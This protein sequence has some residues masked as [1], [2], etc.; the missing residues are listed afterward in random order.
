M[1]KLPDGWSWTTGNR[2]L[3]WTGSD[4]PAHGFTTRTGGL[5]T[6]PFA[7]LNISVRHGDDPAHVDRNLRLIRQD[8]GLDRPWL[9]TDQ[10]HGAEAFVVTR[11]SGI[12]AGTRADALLTNLPDTAIAV[13]VADC[14]P[15]LAWAPDPVDGR[16][17]GVVVAIHAGWRGTAGGVVPGTLARAAQDLG[18]P[19]AKLTFLIGASARSCCYEVG[20]EVVSAL[21]TAL[22]LAGGLSPQDE[23][24]SPPWVDRSRGKARV[25]PAVVAR[26]QLRA[27]GVPVARIHDVGLC[28]LCQ[29]DVWFSYRRDGVRSGRALGIISNGT[30][31]RT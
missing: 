7:S 12:P 3:T 28:T 27:A 16:P 23:Q 13:G 6:G 29:P 14:T 26:A 5:S 2:L 20:D 30:A 8:L 21:E 18:V 24:G 1:T 10:V 11:D 9:T 19:A 15:L 25:S 22:A 4:A 31:R 17:H